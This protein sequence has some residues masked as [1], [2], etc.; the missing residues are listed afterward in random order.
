AVVDRGRGWPKVGEDHVEHGVRQLLRVGEVVAHG[1]R[2]DVRLAGDR[3]GRRSGRAPLAVDARRRGDDPRPGLVLRLRAL[4]ERVGRGH[5]NPSET[6][7][8]WCQSN[9]ASGRCHPALVEAMDPIV[10]VV[11]WLH[12][13]LGILWLGNA[14]ALAVIVIPALNTLPVVRQR[15]IG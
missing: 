4:S 13:L 7:D 9:V 3:E 5:G 12:V 10:V 2:R 1:G 15:E 14:L 8:Y 6:I 11:Q